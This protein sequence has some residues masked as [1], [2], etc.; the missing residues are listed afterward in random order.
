EDAEIYNKG[1]M[2]GQLLANK[3]VVADIKKEKFDLVI[4]VHSNKGGWE[5][6]W[7]I[8]SPIKGDY[9]ETI[10][11]NINNNISWLT[12]YDPPNPTSPEYVTIPLIKS[13]IPAI[14]YEIYTYDSD[15]KSKEQADE[16]V[17]VV[18]N[19]TI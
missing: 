14:I 16:F 1:R 10:A 5:K 8:F 13:G 19:M 18:D 6:K 17:S 11:Q 7:F 12:Y 4:D 9:S 2:N 3:Y 15:I